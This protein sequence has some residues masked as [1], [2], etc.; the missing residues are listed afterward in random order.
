MS[1]AGLPH[2]RIGD[3]QGQKT[4]STSSND[5]PIRKCDTECSNQHPSQLP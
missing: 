3:S 4:F 1:E 5:N 2:P